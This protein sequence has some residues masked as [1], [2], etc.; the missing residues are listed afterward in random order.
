MGT[1]DCAHD[2][3]RRACGRNSFGFDIALS[4]AGG[5]ETEAFDSVYYTALLSGRDPN[6]A[7]R[8]ADFT[9]NLLMTQFGM[10]RSNAVAEVVKFMIWRSGRLCGR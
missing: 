1:M 3:G 7:L 9:A 2:T 5:A 4:R 8:K 6:A 10:T